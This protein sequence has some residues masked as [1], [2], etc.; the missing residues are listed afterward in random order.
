MCLRIAWGGISK[1]AIW[2][3]TSLRYKR[4]E[5]SGR[6]NRPH[7]KADSHNVMRLVLP[8]HGANSNTK[9]KRIVVAQLSHLPWHKV[10]HHRALEE[11]QH[12][13]RDA[14]PTVRNTTEYRMGP[15]RG[16]THKLAYP[17]RHVEWTE[18]D[19][20]GPEVLVKRTHIQTELHIEWAHPV[21]QQAN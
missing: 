5:P 14:Q 6:K 11:S 16:P 4:V 21:G 20:A 13:T 15:T 7:C 9:C 18:L 12:N 3:F 17:A 8:I 10:P 1:V 19:V 2:S